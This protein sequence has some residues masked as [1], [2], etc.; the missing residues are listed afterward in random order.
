MKAHEAMT[1]VL[2]VTA[3]VCLLTSVSAQEE[4]QGT[5]VNTRVYSPALE[6]N[7]LGLAATRTAQVYLPPGYQHSNRRYAVL[8]FLHGGQADY[9]QFFYYDGR[10]S[11]DAL[12]REGSMDP[13]IV[14][15]VDARG[16]FESE[17]I[18][19]NSD[20]TGHCVDYIV[21]DMVSH[22]DANFRTLPRR[23]SRGLFGASAGGGETFRIAMKHPDVFGATYSISI[24]FLATTQPENAIYLGGDVAAMDIVYPNAGEDLAEVQQ[25][26]DIR[27]LNRAIAYHYA[28]IM[29][30]NLDNPPL[31]VDWPFE[32]PSLKII[33]SV[34]EKYEEADEFNML[35]RNWENLLTLRGLAFD[36]GDR[37]E[38]YWNVA[39]LQKLHDRL[40]EYG[41]PHEFDI[42]AGDHTNRRAERIAEAMKFLSSSLITEEPGFV[43][44][45][46]KVGDGL[47]VEWNEAARGFKLQKTL[48]LTSPDWQDVVVP[49]NQTNVVLGT[50]DSQGF[51][52]LVSP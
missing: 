35:D 51:F 34:R 2:T 17:A 4:T 8:Y 45:P 24:G 47:L 30:P 19:G 49:E 39:L 28:A 5:V 31:Y 11:A 48:S 52:R 23:N 7:A 41:V 38:F 13:M 14:V 6:Q 32:L 25:L 20:V 44:V 21:Q 15:G 36:I 12:I 9:N 33:P 18:Y 1:T 43:S 40:L 37:D 16:P 10:Q 50:D 22:I 26:S 42:F 27:T 3:S 46:Q 29:S